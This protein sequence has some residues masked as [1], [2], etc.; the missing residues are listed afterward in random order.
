MDKP[1]IIYTNDSSHTRHFSQ[2]ATSEEICRF[3]DHLAQDG[4][5]DTYA[6]MVFLHGWSC[7]FRTKL[8]EHNATEQYKK[9]NRLFDEGIEPLSIFIERSHH[10]GMEFLAN[11]RMNDRHPAAK[12]FLEKHKEWALVGAG[13]AEGY[14]WAVD[15]S[16]P[17]VREWMLAVME[18]VASRF[19][20]DGLEL[21]FMRWG[22]V[23]PPATAYDSQPIMTDFIRRVRRM[24]DEISERK[25]GRTGL[26]L[27]VRVP[28]TLDECHSL[29]YDVPTWVREGLPDYLCP[30]D[31]FYNDYNAPYGEFSK[32]TKG[33]GCLL[34]PTVQPTIG[35]GY[36]NLLMTLPAYRAAAQNFY[37]CG[38]DGIS[39]FNY[40]YHWAMMSKNI[41]PNLD[42]NAYP[43]PA[44][45]FPD[46]LSYLKELRDPEKVAAGDRHYIFFPLWGGKAPTGATK[47]P[48]IVLERGK[49]ETEGIYPLRLA[50][51]FE[52][53]AAGLLRFNAFDMT[54]E[55]EVAVELNDTLMPADR[56]KR[57][58]HPEG[59]AEGE[60]KDTGAYLSCEFPVTSPPA[61]KGMNLLKVRLVNSVPGIG[62]EIVIPE[63]EVGVS[64]SGR[65][66]VEIMNLLWKRPRGGK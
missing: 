42:D 4:G 56:I 47:N 2:Q 40:M 51:E 38:A 34:Y 35:E 31:F 39:V 45:M 13:F 24:L 6:Q 65:D 46:A 1:R 32:L 64:T 28:Q 53:G 33:T 23:F 54:M 12:S 9:F 27:S 19:D 15:Y 58:F 18:E 44:E 17:E 61:V 50:E 25:G 14:D 20:V 7:L 3:V 63:I 30:S 22:H 57:T 37:A 26:K 5:I 16:I 10:N 55:D 43:G 52:A 11:F 59:R 36:G 8:C 41:Y 66:V 60:G 62:G 48:R 21:D 29:G 49:A